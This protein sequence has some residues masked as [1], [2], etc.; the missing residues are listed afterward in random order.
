MPDLSIGSEIITYEIRVSPHRRTI[1][2]KVEPNGEVTVLAPRFSFSSTIKRF[3]A[4][5]AQWIADTRRKV[6]EHASR[7]PRQ[8]Y[9]QGEPFLFLG[10]EVI[11]HVH[12]TGIRR[13]RPGTFL[14]GRLS[15][16]V[17]QA[18]RESIKRVV[19]LTYE[20]ATLRLITRFVQR[21]AKTLGVRPASIKI[22]GARG[23]WGS[24]S[25]GSRLRFNWR[26][27]MAP[28][29]V[30]EYL[31]VH[32]VCHIKVNGHSKRFWNAVDGLMPGY[33]VQ[34]KWLRDNGRRLMAY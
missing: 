33:R 14:R 18:T 9:R 24:C 19:L 31:A 25:R 28:L 30:I 5:Q 8:E 12:E 10:R 3:V 1:A 13:Y 21:Y 27:A 32:E 29:G 11:L 15:I 20:A 22:S 2:V 4:Q 23:R 34:R 6:L 16:K 7:H 26:L 17:P